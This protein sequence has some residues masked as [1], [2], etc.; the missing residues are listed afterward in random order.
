MND[1]ERIAAGKALRRKVLGDA[2]VDRP[3][4]QPTKFAAAF[5]EFANEHC[6]ANVWIR[7]GLDLRTRSMLNLVMLASL[8]RWPE[9][10]VHI[11]GALNNGVTEDEIVEIILQAGVYAG[12]P[13]A[14]EAF[15]A[16]DRAVAAYKAEKS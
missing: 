16:A 10:E 1:D 8:A 4:P 14:S 13:I 15:R 3:G 6:W 9:F 5:A 2:Y 11:R 7:P 12:I